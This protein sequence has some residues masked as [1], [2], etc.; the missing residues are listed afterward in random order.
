MLSS[1]ELSFQL[2]NTL[3]VM[4]AP[5]V[6]ILVFISIFMAIKNVRKKFIKNK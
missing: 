2:T 3:L 5:I 4:F 1:F 6:L